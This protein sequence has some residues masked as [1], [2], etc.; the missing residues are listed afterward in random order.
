[1]ENETGV[2]STSEETG[3]LRNAEGENFNSVQEQTSVSDSLTAT[4][5]ASVEGQN[6]TVIASSKGGDSKAGKDKDRD[7]SM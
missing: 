7:K 2:E 1:M 5:S 4:S 6:S 3:T